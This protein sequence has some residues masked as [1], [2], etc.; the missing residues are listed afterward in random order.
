[1]L[2]MA[3]FSGAA[4][5]AEPP[6]VLTSIKPI[7]SLVAGVMRGVAEPGLLVKG[8]ASPHAFSLRPSDA[9]AL[10]QA[11]LV[12]WVGEDL[13]TFLEKPIESLGKKAHVVPLM[14]APR[15]KLLPTREG[16]AWEPHVHEEGEEN[17][18]HGEH[19]EHA[20]AGHDH[21][22][23]HGHGHDHHEHGG[24][25]A[26]V[27]LDVAN[28]RAMVAAI[29]AELVE[30]DAANAERYKANAKDLSERLTALDA[31]LKTTLEPVKDRPYVV[32]HDAYHYVEARY[33]LNAVGAITVSPD[34]RPSAQRL[35]QL[36]AKISSL[37]ATC[38][39]AE[40]QFEPTLVGTVVE[41]TKARKG[42][43]DPLGA[44]LP[45]G[46]DLYFQLMR[47]LAGSLVSCL[48]AG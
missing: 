22:H 40:P 6:K 26:H 38:V 12:F 5:S 47:G 33:G 16:G 25:D 46:P 13:E 27:W 45:D 29:S 7:H 4:F 24:K 44:D 11:D 30:H 36:R 17:E 32:F 43:L 48:K 23:D 3:F 9:R 15:V 14:E 42:V 18:E 41:G 39:F 2:G 8:A 28:A 37:D 1:M 31:E 21:D 35:S 34:Q 10:D 20:G 19:A